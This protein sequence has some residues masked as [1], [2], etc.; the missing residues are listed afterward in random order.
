MPCMFDALQ[1]QVSSVKSVESVCVSN[2]MQKKGK[3]KK[4]QEHGGTWRNEG[5]DADTE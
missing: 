5:T 1:W 3:A 2:Y 4:H